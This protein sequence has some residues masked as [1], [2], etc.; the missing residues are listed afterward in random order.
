M[1]LVGKEVKIYV[2]CSSGFRFKTRLS[3]IFISTLNQAA[4]FKMKGLLIL[5]ISLGIYIPEDLLKTTLTN[6][7]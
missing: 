2:N 6:I 3:T 5:L 7:L 4:S 1:I